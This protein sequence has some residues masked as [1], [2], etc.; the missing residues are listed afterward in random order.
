[1]C[2]ADGGLDRISCTCIIFLDCEDAKYGLWRIV[3]GDN[4]LPLLGETGAGGQKAFASHSFGV[5]RWL[6]WI[7]RGRFVHSVRTVSTGTPCGMISIMRAIAASHRPQW[8]A[9][10][11]W[12]T[13]RHDDIRKKRYHH[14]LRTCSRT[15]TVVQKRAAVL[16][17]SSGNE[18]TMSGEWTTS[19]ISVQSIFKHSSSIIME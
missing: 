8:I 19:V 10:R 7:F 12:A 6:L 15:V 9:L 4:H 17:R 1:M 13:L 14:P 5:D 3:T 11:I 16:Y 2:D 18:C